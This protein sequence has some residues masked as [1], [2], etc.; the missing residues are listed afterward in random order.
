MPNRILY[1]DLKGS[2]KYNAVSPAARDLYVRLLLCADDFGRYFANPVIVAREAYPTLEAMTSKQVG[3]L[4]DILA[5]AGLIVR[6]KVGKDDYLLITNWRQRTRAMKSKYPAPDEQ[7]AYDGHPSVMRQS[8]AHGDGDGD[9]DGDG[10]AAPAPSIAPALIVEMY[11]TICVDLPKVRGLTESR[12]KH[13]LPRIKEHP[14]I[15][16]WRRL[17]QRVQTTPFCT[18]DND[19]GWRADFG[20]LIENDTNA[21]KVLEGKYDGGGRRGRAANGRPID[22]APN[23]GEPF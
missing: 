4:L 10:A 17:F 15:E 20:W 21:L 16:W 14:D 23:D 1:D 9:G 11:N 13:L 22:S 6:Y 3:P 18:G 12:R 7:P 5:D 19:R 2:D 8:P